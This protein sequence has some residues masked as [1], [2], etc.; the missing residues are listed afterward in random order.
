MDELIKKGNETFLKLDEILSKHN[1]IKLLTHKCKIERKFRNEIERLEKISKRIGDPKFTT[2]SRFLQDS[3]LNSFEDQI[4]HQ[5]TILD[6][7]LD[8]ES[9]SPECLKITLVKFS[10]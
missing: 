7:L 2:L 8:L 3:I 9:K 1:D 4:N 5:Q 10:K 6:Q